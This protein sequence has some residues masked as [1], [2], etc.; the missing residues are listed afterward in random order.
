LVVYEIGEEEEVARYD[1]NT[2][3]IEKLKSVSR[4]CMHWCVVPDI[5]LIEKVH[6]KQNL[7]LLGWIPRKHKPSLYIKYPSENKKEVEAQTYFAF[8]I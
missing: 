1:I 7:E 5:N 8:D 3:I 2:N 6:E 4:S